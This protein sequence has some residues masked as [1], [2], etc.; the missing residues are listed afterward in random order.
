VLGG[1]VSLFGAGS[2]VRRD[3]GRKGKA[4]RLAK[5]SSVLN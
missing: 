2:G 5:E 4:F 1:V 3:T